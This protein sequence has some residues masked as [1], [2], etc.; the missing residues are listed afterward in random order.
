MAVRRPGGRRPAR[1]HARTGAPRPRARKRPPDNSKKQ[2]E[3]GGPD[4]RFQHGNSA[5]ADTQFR[6]GF[7]GNPAGRPR[8]SRAQLTDAFFQDLLAVWEVAGS[9]VLRR[10]A[11]RDTTAFLSIVAG[12][13]PRK[14]Q[15][16]LELPTVEELVASYRRRHPS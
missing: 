7:S 3:T 5:G 11:V 8:G 10:C 12:L 16:D 9:G 13:M 6:P 1:K 2:A 14:A 4:T 15:L